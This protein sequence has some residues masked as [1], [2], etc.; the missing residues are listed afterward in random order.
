MESLVDM[1]VVI[2]TRN[3][4]QSIDQTLCDL[5]GQSLHGLRAEVVV[6]DNGSADD[7]K[8]VL[9]RHKG[10]LQLVALCEPIPGKSRALNTAIAQVRGSLIVFTDDDIAIPSSWLAEIY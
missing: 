9:E 3:R 8:A 1:S 10:N 7:T 4:S 5:E 6:V 2:C